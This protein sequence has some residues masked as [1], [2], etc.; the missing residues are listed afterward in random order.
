[1][2]QGVPAPAG[3]W[4]GGGGKEVVMGREEY[5]QEI[6]EALPCHALMTGRFFSETIRCFGWYPSGLTPG[7]SI[8]RWH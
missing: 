5:L 7:L 8:L 3:T 1:M 2:L 6:M 4:Q